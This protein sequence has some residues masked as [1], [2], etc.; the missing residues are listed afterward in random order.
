MVE[1]AQVV[2]EEVADVVD[3]VLRR[4]RQGA[5]LRIVEQR[6][7]LKIACTVRPMGRETIETPLGPLDCER[8]LWRPRPGKELHV[9]RTGEARV[10]NRHSTDIVPRDL[11]SLNLDYRQM[12]VG[13]DDSW[14]AQTHDPYRLLA[15]RE[16]VKFLGNWD[17]LG[18][19][20]TGAVAGG[21]VVVDASASSQFISALLLAGGVL[22][23]A[24]VY[25]AG[26]RAT[27]AMSAA[28]VRASGDGTSTASNAPA[29]KRSRSGA[30]MRN[31]SDMPIPPA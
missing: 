4:K 26:M 11:V 23:Q 16:T 29:M 9:W 27:R 25:P 14:G 15:P 24:H 21:T 6:H 2:C 22:P 7:G 8:F 3:A 13:G 18:L 31:A 12:G 5:R 1:E 20:G 17:V 28:I 19:R 10:P 30:L